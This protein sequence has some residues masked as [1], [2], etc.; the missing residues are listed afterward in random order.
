MQTQEQPATRKE[1]V[2]DEQGQTVET[3]EVAAEEVVEGAEAGAEAA[4]AAPTP[5]KYRIG[6]KEFA[7]QDEALAYATSEISAKDTEAQVADAYRQGIRDAAA[8]PPGIQPGVTLPAAPAAPPLNTEELYTNPQEFLRKYGEGIKRDVIA[9]TS[10][11]QNLRAQSDQI[12]SEFTTR[13][14]ELADF[15]SEVETFVDGNVTDVRSIISTKG[16]PASYDWIATKLK[17]RFE[18]YSNALKPKRELPNTSGGASPTQRASGVTPPA[19]ANK[20]LSFS[21][22]L[23]TIR[24]KS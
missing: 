2:F 22:Q 19:P 14:P 11:Q 8:H 9:E 17:S 4:A 16:R 13:H 3:L 10:Q 21:E 18:G 1:V 6:D 7:T 23:R 12:W 24:K 20:L 15:R 5:A